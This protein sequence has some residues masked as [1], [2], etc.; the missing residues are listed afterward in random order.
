MLST[1]GARFTRCAPYH[2]Q[3]N[4]RRRGRHVRVALRQLRTERH[5]DVARHDPGR[6]L[7][8]RSRRSE[9]FLG[10]SVARDPEPVEARQPLRRSRRPEAPSR[11]RSER[12]ERERQRSLRLADDERRTIHEHA[13]GE[14]LPQL[15]LRDRRGRSDARLGVLKRGVHEPA[16]RRARHPGQ[17]VRLLQRVRRWRPPPYRLPLVTC[18]ARLRAGHLRIHEERRLP[19]A[20]ATRPGAR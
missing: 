5:G 16:L 15:L 14:E 13:R 20:V 18:A 3:A 6:R 1:H 7:H 11:Q 19:A 8:R 4:G 12:H 17:R 9:I 10:W 2:Y